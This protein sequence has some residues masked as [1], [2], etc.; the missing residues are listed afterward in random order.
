MYNTLHHSATHY[1]RSQELDN[2]GDSG[3]HGDL[4]TAWWR[5]VLLSLAGRVW[6]TT[7]SKKTIHYHHIGEDNWYHCRQ[8]SNTVTEYYIARARHSMQSFSRYMSV[9]WDPELFG[10]DQKH[11]YNK[12]KCCHSLGWFWQFLWQFVSIDETLFVTSSTIKAVK[13][14]RFSAFHES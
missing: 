10:P 4:T 7:T 11:Q 14:L 12:G 1:L 5:S 3:T 2:Q 6:K 9:H 13:T 8:M